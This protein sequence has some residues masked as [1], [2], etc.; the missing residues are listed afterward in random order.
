MIPTAISTPLLIATANNGCFCESGGSDRRKH[1]GNAL[2]AMQ[3]I[4]D[5][6]SLNGGLIIVVLE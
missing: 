3:R 4:P 5:V 1:L 2:T 6:V